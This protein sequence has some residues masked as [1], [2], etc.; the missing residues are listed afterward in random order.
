MFGHTFSLA[1]LLYEGG[2]VTSTSYKL[3][4]EPRTSSVVQAA[5]PYPGSSKTSSSFGNIL[6]RCRFERASIS[7][8]PTENRG[9]NRF[10]RG[11]NG[12][13]CET[14]DGMM[15]RMDKSYTKDH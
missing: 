7:C 14:E 10:G 9:L 6:M 13:R 15:E 12:R 11:S 5:Q 1:C 2:M 4:F 3:A 8:T